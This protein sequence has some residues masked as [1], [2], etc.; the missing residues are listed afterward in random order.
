MSSSPVYSSFGNSPQYQVDADTLIAYLDTASIKFVLPEG[1]AD[2]LV[3]LVDPTMRAID[4]QTLDQI[5]QRLRKAGYN[6][7]SA[8]T[9][10]NV[11]VQVAKAQGVSPFTYFDINSNT[12]KLTSDTY[13]IINSLRASGNRIGLVNPN[14]PVTPAVQRLL[15]P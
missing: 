10:A 5:E 2:M 13:Q 12:L 1:S 9:M 6:A 4:P 14:R 15:R 3:A 11:L 8:A 7:V